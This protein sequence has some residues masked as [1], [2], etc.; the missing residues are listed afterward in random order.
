M[1]YIGTILNCIIG[2]LIIIFAKQLQGLYFG[3]SVLIVLITINIINIINNKKN[4]S[5]ENIDKSNLLKE[6]NLSQVFTDELGEFGENLNEFLQDVRNIIANTYSLSQKLNENT[7]IIS[8]NVY[9]NSLAFDETLSS[10]D[11]L[12]KTMQYQL[13]E[14]KKLEDT[15]KMLFEHA[16]ISKDN[17]QRAINEVESMNDTIKHNKEVF[18]KVVNLLKQS[19]NAGNNMADEIITLTKEVKDIYNITDEVENISKQTNLLALNAAIEAARAGEAG[20]GFAVVADEI[21][22][23][24]VQSSQSVGKI[25]QI[26]NSVTDKITFISNKMQTEMNMINKDISIADESVNSLGNIYTKSEEVITDVRNI[27]ESS[28]KQLGLTQEVNEIIKEFTFIVDETN[29]VSSKINE[30]GIEHSSEIQ[31][32]ASSVAQ[33]E[34]MSNDT[35]K[36]MKKYLDSFKLD[37]NMNN[38]INNAFDILNKISNKENILSKDTNTSMRSDLK[39]IVKSNP[40]FEVIC[41]LNKDGYSAVS[42]I[43]EEDLVQNFKHRDYFKKSINGDKFKSNPYISVD[44]GHYCVAIATPIRNEDQTILGCIMADVIIG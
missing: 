32:V 39:D 44:T 26:I 28:N 10:I 29:K 35:Y 27:Y 17:S 24:A 7:N 33:L 36:Y 19:K 23:L 6:R 16:S 2:T 42:N 11:D 18:T 34:D 43:D 22:E 5:Q 21:R 15:S 25:S 20:R 3:I 8:N 40:Y 38:T 30:D 12:S 31:S 13:K 37:D 14:I 41:V 4:I 9:N 1:K